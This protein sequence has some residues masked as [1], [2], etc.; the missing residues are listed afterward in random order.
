[1][2]LIRLRN[3]K[4]SLFGIAAALIISGV[5]FF[6]QVLA[7]NVTANWSYDYGPMPACSGPRT[8][9]CIDH[10]EVLDISDR[11]K[12]VVIRSV[13]NPK[14]AVGKVG[15]I[16]A[17]FKYGPPF[18]QRTISVIAVGR[19]PNGARITS[20]PDAARVTVSIHPSARMSLVF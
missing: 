13:D 7:A 19:D 18:G 14:A 15:K 4:R 12:T 16:S 1:M 2:S 20:D 17:D 5:V 6:G 11:K 3:A 9:K 8:A 10:F